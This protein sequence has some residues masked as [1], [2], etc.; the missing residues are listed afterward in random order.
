M[1]R[2]FE[3]PLDEISNC[4]LTMGNFDGLHMGHR[5]VITELIQQAKNHKTEPVILSYL[6]HPGH[7]IH[8]KHPVPILTPRHMKKEQLIA[9]GVNQ[10]YF[11]N[12]TAEVAH[13]SA[14]NFL[15]EVVVNYFNPKAIV[16]GY[17]SHFGYRREGSPEFL[18][19]HEKEFGYQTY[20][21]EPV[22]YQSEIISS[23]SIREHLCRGN[24]SQANAML[25]KPYCLY[26]TVTHGYKYGRSI[27]F[28]TINLN[29][30]DAE[31]LIPKN[32]VY[33]SS[34]LIAGKQYFG[35]TN[36]GTSPTLKNMNQIEIE[37]YILDFKND[38]YEENI[39]LELLEYLREE[40]VFRS[41]EELKEAIAADIIQ[42][43]KIIS[44]NK[45]L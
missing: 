17:D 31:Q 2:W 38:V 24:I 29:L 16:A 5:K 11:L 4:V 41:V 15:K 7:F 36:I 30:S 3:E 1:I 27:G 25:V 8:F 13:T 20:H 18:I 33:L 19:K 23:S 39:Q 34:L 22:Y 6:E 9:T 12:F 42:G 14:Y 40:K 44:G 32:G 26:G 10:V 45:Y 37:T 43:R 28:P 35:L 21:I